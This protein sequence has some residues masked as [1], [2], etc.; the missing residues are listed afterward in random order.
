MVDL[1]IHWQGG[2]GIPNWGN[3]GGRGWTGGVPGRDFFDAPITNAPDG[4]FR[5][6]DI[7][8]FDA[9]F[10][11]DPSVR[12]LVADRI[13]VDQLNAYVNTKEYAELNALD[14]AFITG[15]RGYFSA[16]VAKADTVEFLDKFINLYERLSYWDIIRVHLGLVEI[17]WLRNN[18]S[19][20][21][22]AKA[23]CFCR[24]TEI[25][26]PSGGCKRIEDIRISDAVLAFEAPDKMN[27]SRLRPSK[28]VRVFRGITTEW[29][30]LSCGLIVTPGHRFLNEFGQFERIDDLIARG[31]RIVLEDGT[32][33][34]VTAER[35]AYSEETR[36]LY[37]EAEEVVYASFGGTALQPEIRR[38]W[39]TYNFEVEELHTYIA[40]GV[41]VHNDSLQNYLN[42]SVM[43]KNDAYTAVAATDLANQFGWGA[44]GS[45]SWSSEP[46]AQD[47]F[48]DHLADMVDAYHEA[49]ARND[50]ETAEAIYGGIDSVQSGAR[51]AKHEAERAIAENPLSS[52][53]GKFEAERDN[54]AKAE[55]LTEQAKADMTGGQPGRGGTY[56]GGSS[57][58]DRNPGNNNDGRPE[59]DNPNDGDN[60]PGTAP[61]SGG[62]NLSVGRWFASDDE[63]RSRGP[64]V[65]GVGPATV[66]RYE[67]GTIYSQVD[68][69][70][71]QSIAVVKD[72]DVL[73]LSE[74]EIRKDGTKREETH[75]AL[76][77]GGM[78][79]TVTIYDKNDKITSQKTWVKNI[80]RLHYKHL[81]DGSQ[82]LYQYDAAGLLKYLISTE[83]D[84]SG[85]TLEYNLSAKAGEW[86]SKKSFF[87]KKGVVTHAELTH[88]DSQVE[89]VSYR[90][91]YTLEPKRN[92][93]TLGED[94]RNGTGNIYG[95]LVLGNGLDNELT[96]LEGADTLKGGAGADVLH[97]GADSD[98]LFGDEGNDVLHGGEGSDSL[99]GG[100]GAD[101]L[102]GGTGNDTLGG[103]TG[104]DALSGDE[105]NDLLSG[106]NGNDTLVGGAGNDVLNGEADR[107]VLHGGA[108]DDTLDGGGGADGLYGEDDHDVLRG[109]AG[110]DTLDGGIGNDSLDGGGWDDSLEGGS[111]HDTLLGGAGYDTL[112]GGVGNDSLDGGTEDDRLEGGEGS[113]TLFGGGGVDQLYGGIGHDVL[114]GSDG[115]DFLYGEAGNDS[116]VGGEGSDELN[117]GEDDDTLNGGAGL[118][119]L[120]GGGGNDV[121][122]GGAETDML[123]GGEGKDT[124]LGGDGN[125]TLE[126]GAGHDSLDGGEGNDRLRGDVGNDT[127]SGY[128]GNDD[129]DGGEDDDLLYGH[130][131]DD[132]LV[133]SG[134]NDTLWG[135]TG[136]DALGGYEGNDVLHGE[137]GDD[138]LKGGADDDLLY[139]GLDNDT[140]YGGT[141]NDRLTGAE[142]ED[143]LYGDAGDDTLLG[144]S[145]SDKLWG[146]ADADRLEGHEG[147]DVLEGGDGD[148]SLLGGLGDDMLN[149]GIGNDTL[150]G[151]G[152]RDQIFGREGN[153]ILVGG[154]DVDYIDGGGGTDI[155]VLTGR[156]SDYLI[157]FNS[158]IGRFSIVDLRAGSPDGTD[159]AD[160]EIFR[161][162]DGD[163]AKAVLDYMTNTDEQTAWDVENSDGSRNTLGWRACPE[164][165]GQLEAFIQRR[166]ITNDL[167]SET[168]FKP[169]GS[170]ISYGWD[171]N[172][173][174]PWDS[175]IQTFDAQARL[176]RQQY[177]TGSQ[178][179]IEEWDPDND[180]GQDWSYRVIDLVKIGGEYFAH[181]QL[182]TLD[183]PENGPDPSIVDHIWRFWD[184]LGLYGWSEIQRELDSERRVLIDETT[185]D[186]GGRIRI[187]RDYILD[188]SNY[189]SDG[190]PMEWESFE[191][192]Y[193]QNGNKF[194]E[195]YTYYAAAAEGWRIVIK[196][197]DF[198]NEDWSDSTLYIAGLDRNLW[199]DTNYDT[200]PLYSWTREEWGYDPGNWSKRTTHFDKLNDTR[201][202]SQIDEWIG[203][204]G[205]VTRN[206]IK[207]WDYTVAVEWK[208]YEALS[209]LHNGLLTVEEE[210][211][212]FD[213]ETYKVT[214]HDLA[215]E[216][217]DW[218]VETVHYFSESTSQYFYKSYV[219]EDNT[220][221]EGQYDPRG[222]DGRWVHNVVRYTD[223][224]RATALD[225]E[226]LFD[227]GTFRKV[228]HD[229]FNARSNE[230][231]KYTIIYKTAAQLPTEVIYGQYIYD[232]NTSLTFEKDLLGRE[233]WD[234]RTT[235][236]IYS[237]NPL[238]WGIYYQEIIDDRVNGR[239]KK[240]IHEWDRPGMSKPWVQRT[241][242]YDDGTNLSKEE[243]TYSNKFNEIR[244]NDN[245]I[246]YDK[247][248]YSDGKYTIAET[249]YN[250]ETWST[251]ETKGAKYD[252]V[253]KPYFKKTFYESGF[254]PQV[255]D[256]WDAGDTRDWDYTQVGLAKNAQGQWYITGVETTFDDPSL[257]PR[258]Q[259]MPAE[260]LNNLEQ[261]WIGNSD[262]AESSA[263]SGMTWQE[264]LVFDRNGTGGI[265]LDTELPLARSWL[266]GR[267]AEEGHLIM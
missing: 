189:G 37:E 97:G 7:G 213:N 27:I 121:L 254:Y 259:Y 86:K 61:P 5:D 17:S 55:R 196:E 122:D 43:M 206:H 253:S 115:R 167:M 216:Q 51:A 147:D 50:F 168:V 35:I 78:Q 204:N 160:I 187:G 159:L 155:I 179:K 193:D 107:D 45:A 148:D 12:E 188:G 42:L 267:V 158:A 223:S 141:G 174:E 48:A 192:H 130:G 231:S 143:H 34:S 69:G 238:Q 63:D 16:K 93:L 244:Y 22:E 60:V 116:L 232:N 165:P 29:L 139:G 146:G 152:G 162:S 178:R 44:V 169:D 89:I 72:K 123:L 56:G 200:H 156:R 13:L 105:G 234:K 21:T 197:W 210:R 154:S 241:Q 161:F 91:S 75:A 110:N 203:A 58:P 164:A 136:K 87:T 236:E 142:D 249:D 218:K 201:E 138:V 67:D 230:W 41:R 237:G 181:E 240:V 80:L 95:N 248:V 263:D 215:G 46:F 225:E 10:D 227:D 265:E 135:G 171:V 243:I 251:R 104:H 71:K 64:I 205:V 108:G 207:H 229:P 211:T 99:D 176:V 81:P 182:D 260:V 131:G 52:A 163:I 9:S 73:A 23:K 66:T 124:L 266:L 47:G 214:K 40:G 173:T 54:Y 185:F 257:P 177:D 194:W 113:D 4:F 100:T 118:D 38:G 101:M 112:K 220:F 57:S 202:L 183:E 62:E 65:M 258:Q 186:D 190:R 11:L 14:K 26:L 25:L 114:D 20:P 8:Y 221:T 247:W 242:T 224:G 151:G 74:T 239:A 85:W 128:A 191:A 109:G 2:W 96:G 117:G 126:G 180:Y 98:A 255:R 84:K 33:A 137:G 49:I 103:D 19:V 36:H 18:S 59:H 261:G 24:G 6:H 32:L 31:G 235:K 246:E 125:D 70:T 252:R 209:R 90:N 39:R 175:Y 212:L 132:A 1:N 184:P 264:L 53:R 226:T 262:L 157:R 217:S 127:L 92:W 120:V 106:G 145:G 3:Y 129:L 94:A 119:W 30:V 82:S 77:G 149:G 172:G 133:G 15:A 153:D 166:S 219:W 208:R 256:F 233:M 140:L 102:H 245:R 79:K 111:G 134:G 199:K 170:R 68:S 195:K 150:D 228:T 144:G 198:H 83:A 28:V 250:G 76:A 88:L 222:T